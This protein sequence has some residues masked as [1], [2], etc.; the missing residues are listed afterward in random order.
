MV[1]CLWLVVWV[2]M[3]DARL[4]NP[5]RI[6]ATVEPDSKFKIRTVFTNPLDKP[7]G[8]VEYIKYH[9]W[10]WLAWL[11]AKWLTIKHPFALVDIQVKN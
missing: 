4:D 2:S 6:A 1:S 8:N 9:R 11:Y 5:Y 7:Y 10:I 3:M